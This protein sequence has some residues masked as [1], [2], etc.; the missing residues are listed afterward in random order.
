MWSGRNTT[1][2]YKLLALCCPLNHTCNLVPE[3]SSRQR[4]MYLSSPWANAVG[5]RGIW[6]LHPPPTSCS[7]STRSGKAY[8]HSQ[9]TRWDTRRL[10]PLPSCEWWTSECPCCFPRQVRK[11]GWSGCGRPG[12]V[13]P[14]AASSGRLQDRHEGSRSRICSPIM[15]SLMDDIQCYMKM[16]AI[17]RANIVSSLISEVAGR[18]KASC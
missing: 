14:S 8:P 17:R 11:L 9:S 7:N 18:H 6:F 12:R 4:G 13:L 5:Q 10:V 16:S 2:K 15:L 1:F 3:V